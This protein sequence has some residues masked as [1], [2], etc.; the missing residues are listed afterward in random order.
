MLVSIIGFHLTASV[1]DGAFPVRER[2]GQ[3][4]LA[5][6]GN[7]ATGLEMKEEWS[8]ELRCVK[9]YFSSTLLSFG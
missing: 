5:V 4:T 7:E 3:C 9:V 6:L 1:G 2:N 8:T